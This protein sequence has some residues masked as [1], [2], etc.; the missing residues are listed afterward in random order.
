M[1]GGTFF[2][3]IVTQNRQPLFTEDANVARLRMAV[4]N[5]REHHPFTLDAAVILPDH[6]HLV[7]TMP[8]T[9]SNYSS[10]IGRIKVT[11]TRSLGL[12]SYEESSGSQ[13]GYSGIWQPRFWEHRIRDHDDFNNH[14]DYIHYNPVKHGYAR[15]P[16][17]WPH[18][19]FGKWV[20]QEG[21]PQTWCC[22]CDGRVVEPPDLKE[23]ADR[24]GE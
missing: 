1:P 20:R 23:I 6:V 13:R 15:C 8:Q 9:D 12:S 22:C 10:R 11:F 14:L 16:H 18:S 3:T 21:Y 24:V 19:S 5:E 17:E 7:W 2:F 4:R